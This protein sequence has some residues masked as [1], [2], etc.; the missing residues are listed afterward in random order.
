M[1]AGDIIRIAPTMSA[2][3]ML[4]ENVRVVKKKKKS[5][6]DLVG[7]AT[8]NI[9]GISLIRAQSQLAADIV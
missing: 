6:K 3:A 1:T 9:V 2:L 4:G 5:T 7:L 8:T